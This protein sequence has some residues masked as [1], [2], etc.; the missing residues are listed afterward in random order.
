MSKVLILLRIS[1][2]YELSEVPE[3]VQS[4][5]K[6]LT[7]FSEMHLALHTNCRLDM[8]FVHCILHITCN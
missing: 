7:R 8:T 4:Y 1:M 2:C 6:I 3:F 5:F